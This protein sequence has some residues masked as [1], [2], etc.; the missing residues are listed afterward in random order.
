MNRCA[1]CHPDCMACMWNAEHGVTLIE[2]PDGRRLCAAHAEMENSR[3]E[4]G[5]QP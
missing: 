2:M 5:E 3:Q 4:A 1:E